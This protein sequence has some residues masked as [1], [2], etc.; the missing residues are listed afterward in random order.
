MA[1]R[2]V[3]D[4]RPLRPQFGVERVGIG[5]VYVAGSYPLVSLFVQF[6]AML[7]PAWIPGPYFWT[8]FAGIALIAGGAGLILLQTARLT[9]A[10]TGLMIFLWLVLLHIPRAVAAAD[11]QS[12]RNE[13]TSVFEAIAISGIAFVLAGSLRN[14]SLD[15]VRS[16]IILS[17]EKT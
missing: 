16:G 7:V 4:V 5:H 11:P 1:D 14:G 12:S 2:L 8:Y 10:L 15:S 9:A 3:Q 6:V 17:N 13:W